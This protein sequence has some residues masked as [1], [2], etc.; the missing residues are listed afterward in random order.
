MFGIGIAGEAAGVNLIAEQVDSFQM[1]FGWP[2]DGHPTEG[3]VIKIGGDWIR[4]CVVDLGT[5]ATA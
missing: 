2:L 5:Y 4:F 3:Q 1:N